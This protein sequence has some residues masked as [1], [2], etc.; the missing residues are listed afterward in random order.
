LV[1]TKKEICTIAQSIPESRQNDKRQR[2]DIA[3]LFPESDFPKII[4]ELPIKK[5]Y[6]DI[7]YVPGAIFRNIDRKNYN[8]SQLN[9]LITHKM[10]K[11]MTI[12]NINTVRALADEKR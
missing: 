3:F 12:R 6:V 1:K 9:K 11:C 4:D 10:Y 7:R 8:K 5:E 2:S